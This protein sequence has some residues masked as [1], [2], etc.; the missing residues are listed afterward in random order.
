M[1]ST[2]PMLAKTPPYN[3]FLGKEDFAGPFKASYTAR[4]MESEEAHESSQD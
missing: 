3:T 1:F 4:L 2:Y